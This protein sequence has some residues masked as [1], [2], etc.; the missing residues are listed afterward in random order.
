M[1]GRHYEA[2]EHCINRQPDINDHTKQHMKAAHQ[3]LNHPARLLQS[4]YRQAVKSAALTGR[5]CVNILF[6]IM[7]CISH[8]CST[9]PN[10]QIQINTNYRRHGAWQQQVTHPKTE[11]HINSSAA[12]Y[13][14]WRCSQRCEA[15]RDVLG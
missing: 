6:D 7:S 3:P 11:S 9:L 8:V 10:R 14:V 5:R 15:G 12:M 13:R 4:G 1:D 2:A